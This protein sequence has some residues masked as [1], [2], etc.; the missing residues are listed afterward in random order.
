LVIGLTLIFFQEYSRKV[1]LLNIGNWGKLRGRIG[2]LEA[3]LGIE[4]L[5][6]C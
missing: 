5:I 3:P 1:N 6:G 2:L 4:F